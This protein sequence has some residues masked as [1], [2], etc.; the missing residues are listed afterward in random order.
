MIKNSRRAAALDYT[1]NEYILLYQKKDRVYNKLMDCELRF[2]TQ[3][4][5][6]E[7]ISHLLNDRN[8][9]QYCTVRKDCF[10]RGEGYKWTEVK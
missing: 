6:D 3:E 5:M 4:D 8:V 2:G 7:F 1:K 10:M 9:I